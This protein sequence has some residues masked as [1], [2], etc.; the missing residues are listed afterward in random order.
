M[1]CMLHLVPLLVGDGEL[2]TVLAPGRGAGP[3]S[4]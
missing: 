4:W 1:S 3:R 2:L